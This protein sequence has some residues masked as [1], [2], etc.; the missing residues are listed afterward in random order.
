MWPRGVDSSHLLNRL[1]DAA[2]KEKQKNKSFSALRSLTY[3]NV[4][5]AEISQG[6]AVE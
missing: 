4:T 6:L 2:K 3:V 1:A 5:L